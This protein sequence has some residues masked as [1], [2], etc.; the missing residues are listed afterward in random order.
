[1]TLSVVQKSMLEHDIEELLTN[2]CTIPLTT[3]D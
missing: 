1:M 3:A 2:G